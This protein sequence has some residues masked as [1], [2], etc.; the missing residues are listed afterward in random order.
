MYV[1]Q[2]IYIYMYV[3]I[4]AR[5]KDRS[6]YCLN[7]ENLKG[8]APCRVKKKKRRR[9]FFLRNTLAWSRELSLLFFFLSIRLSAPSLSLRP[10]PLH[11]GVSLTPIHPWSSS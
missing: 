4:S 3:Y 8:I 7:K 5:K 2:I 1:L 11:L 10:P 9:K 6:N